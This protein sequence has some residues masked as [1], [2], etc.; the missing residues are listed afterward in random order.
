VKGIAWKGERA[1]LA[2]GTDVRIP[3]GDSLNFLGAGSVGVKPFVVWSYRARVSPHLGAG[4]EA[5]GSS[6]VVGDISTGSKE[7]LPGQFTYSAGADVWLNKR[8]TAAFDL[9]GQTLFQTSRLIPSQYTELG[10]CVYPP[11]HSYPDCAGSFAKPNVDA[12]L[13]QSFRTLNVLNASVGLKVRLFSNLLFTGN[14]VLK[15][16]DGGLRAKVIPMAELSY[17]F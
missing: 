15:T 12:N 4:F 5:N 17:T 13:T 11:L 1:G 14:A 7:R 8:V 6:R 2:L 9:V 3:T 10:A 16:N